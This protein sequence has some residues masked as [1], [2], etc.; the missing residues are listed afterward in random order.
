MSDPADPFDA[1]EMARIHADL[2]SEQVNDAIVEAQEEVDRAVEAIGE[3]T[4]RLR[5]LI[6]RAAVINFVTSVAVGTAV[7]AVYEDVG[8]G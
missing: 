2:V 5:T 7:M 3:L 1:D 6:P 8:D 4:A